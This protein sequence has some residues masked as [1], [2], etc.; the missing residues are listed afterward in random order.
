MLYGAYPNKA[1]R[2]K[3]SLKPVMKWTSHVAF[4]RTFPSGCALS[5]GGRYVTE[6]EAT[7][8]AYVPVGYADGYPRSLSNR[9][10]ML[11]AGRRRPILGTICMD[12]V[13]LDVTDPPGVG[14]G[15]EVVVMG[16]AEDGNITADEIAEQTGTIPYE[17]LCNVSKRVPEALCPLKS[18][19]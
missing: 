9:G 6:R 4:V 1:L 12:W 11:I 5:Y 13:F 3:I 18:T 10:A 7:R 8:V 15:E 2:E 16:G 17:V 19:R 14:P